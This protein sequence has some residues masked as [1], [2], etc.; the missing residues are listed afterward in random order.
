[1][2]KCKKC[3]EL[4]ELSEFNKNKNCTIDGHINKCKSCLSIEQKIKYQLNKE[5]IKRK[6][7]ERRLNN[8]ERHKEIRDKGYR[9]NREKNRIREKIWREKNKEKIRES[10]KKYRGENKDILSKK[11]KIYLEKNK[12]KYQKY[13][14]EY[15]KKKFEKRKSQREARKNIIKEYNSNYKKYR[16]DNDLIYRL[17]TNMSKSINSAFKRCGYKKSSRTHEILGCSFEDFKL[18][19]ESKFEP[20]MTW[21]NRGKYN[22]D[23]N[24]GWD[25]DHI[26]P[27]STAKTE[28][29]V[30]RLNH[31]TNFQPLCSYTN[32]H[33]KKNKLDESY[34]NF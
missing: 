31:Y 2:K 24:H 8:P 29:D 11:K 7:N 20:W 32:R 4:K 30:I 33:L 6:V 10:G 9:K 22:G 18:Y 34:K 25:L 17:H 26:I 21:D 1:M 28:E 19:L 13:F 14:H 15:N 12:E 16:Y 27:I 3:G 5:D 23:L